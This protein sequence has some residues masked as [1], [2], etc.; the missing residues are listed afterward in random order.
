VGYTRFNDPQ[1]F[2]VQVVLTDE[3]RLLA[4][5]D[6][7]RGRCWRIQPGN[8]PLL[9]PLNGQDVWGTTRL[10][11]CYNGLVLLRQG[12]ERHYFQ[13]SAV[14]ASAQIQL[15]TEPNWNNG[16]LVQFVAM[17]NSYFTPAVSSGSVPNPGSQ[18]YVKTLTGNLVELFLD[19]GLTT[20]INFAGAYGSFYLMR[21]ASTP[22]FYGNGAPPLLAQPNAI[23]NTLWDDGFTDVPTAVQVTNVTSNVI[24]APNH[25]LLP[26]DAITV[27]G[28]TLTGGGALAVPVYANPTSPN[29]LQLY[30]NAND[31]LAA[32]ATGLQ[33][34]ANNSSPTTATIVKSGASGLPMPPGREGCYLENRLVIV[35]Q[36]CTLAISDPLDP[37][38]FTP[39]TAAV[40][41]NLGESDNVQA[42]VPLPL[43]DSLL[44]LK[45]NEVLLLSNFS[46]GS[47]AWSLTTVT[48]EYGCFAPLSAVQVGADVWFF[49]RKGVAS[50]TQTI[51]GIT[52]GVAEP[53]SKPLQKYINLIDWRNAAMA[54]ACYWNNRFYL[55]VP[56]KGQTGTVV[57]NAWLVYNFLNQAW[58]GMWQGAALVASGMARL[59]VFGDERLCFI[60]PSGQVQWLGDGFADGTTPVSDSM[61]TRIYTCSSMTR[62]L[63]LA[64]DATWDSYA[65]SITVTAQTPGENEAEVL[66]PSPILYNRLAY[67]DQGYGPYVPG[68]SPFN[69][70]YREDYQISAAE[71]TEGAPDTHQNHTEG[72]RHRLDDWGIQYVIANTTGSL[73]IQ[74]VQIRA[75]A[76]PSLDNAQV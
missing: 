4:G 35:N 20:Q 58:E 24:T 57:N 16:D 76:G 26:G 33:G 39:F 51:N 47:S 17:P 23:G 72:F 5:E 50:I 25:N 27:T 34:L 42:L 13:A 31:A 38:H 62:K 52:Q 66:L 11:P 36:A 53:V 45:Q 29:T 69:A 18:Y 14:N 74:S 37:L 28:V 8:E 40:T 22:G 41:A 2:D 15:N 59:T 43:L 7:G 49:S 65:P 21:N 32:G 30:D 73:R 19:Q 63:H 6:G 60:Q 61:T 12:N 44:I 10:I 75:V 48:R 68:T 67:A 54:T 71:L 55:A 64:M 3:W 70:P 46:Q 56:L 1:G 9:V